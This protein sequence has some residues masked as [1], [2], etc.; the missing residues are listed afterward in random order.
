MMYEMGSKKFHGYGGGSPR[1]S[2]LTVST[3][4]LNSK[5]TRIVVLMLYFV[6]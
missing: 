6:F 5:L 2:S 4:T 1:H 3:R